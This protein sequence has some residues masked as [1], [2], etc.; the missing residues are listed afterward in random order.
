[1]HFA[2]GVDDL[3]PALVAEEAV[4]EAFAVEAVFD[5]VPL[6]LAAVEVIAVLPAGALLDALG[7]AA[8]GADFAA[9]AGAAVLLTPP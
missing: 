3:A 9:V 7:A 2:V 6:G 8:G 4:G 1:M 5:I